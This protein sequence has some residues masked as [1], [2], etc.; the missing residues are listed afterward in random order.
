LALGGGSAPAPFGAPAPSTDP[1]LN[2]TSAVIPEAPTAAPLPPAAI[3]AAKRRKAQRVTA[4]IIGLLALAVIGL[5]PVLIYV[6]F[7]Q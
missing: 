4:L 7:R 1:R 3:L 2:P 6:L 5:V